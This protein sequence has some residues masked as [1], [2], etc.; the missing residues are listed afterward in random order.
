MSKRGSH[1]PHEAQPNWAWVPLR[2]GSHSAHLG[3]GSGFFRSLPDLFPDSSGCFRIFV[4]KYSKNKMFLRPLRFV[5]TDFQPVRSHGDPFSASQQFQNFEQI[6]IIFDEELLL[7]GKTFSDFA[8][9][10]RNLPMS[11]LF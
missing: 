8:S 1:G 7:P 2:P 10:G 4:Q 6:S 9:V 5:S 3:P 11:S